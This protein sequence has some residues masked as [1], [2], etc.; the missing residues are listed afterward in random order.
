M[1][2]HFLSSCLQLK[3]L[4]SSVSNLE[5]KKVDINYNMIDVVNLVHKLL[6]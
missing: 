6:V 1:H 4:F 5:L 2:P 3:I